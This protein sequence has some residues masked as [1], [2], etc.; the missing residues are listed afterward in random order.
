MLPKKRKFDL[1]KFELDRGEGGGGAGSSHTHCVLAPGGSERPG[2]NVHQMPPRTEVSLSGARALPASGFLTPETVHEAFAGNSYLKRDQAR[3]LMS[4][5]G[6]P[7]RPRSGSSPGSSLNMNNIVDLSQKHSDKHESSVSVS[8]TPGPGP[9]SQYSAFSRPSPHLPFPGAL[10]RL[11][12]ELA[13]NTESTQSF[14]RMSS[15]PGHSSEGGGS[16][17]GSGGGVSVVLQPAPSK[18]PSSAS[19]RSKSTNAPHR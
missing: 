16:G 18:N 7:P 15:T 14:K 9:L 12:P 13:P 8:V 2:H 10:A 6:P 1:S 17:G 19:H 11:K 4:G 5:P 3:L